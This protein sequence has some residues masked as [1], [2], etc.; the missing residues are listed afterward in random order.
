M[1]ASGAVRGPSSFS[2]ETPRDGV[3]A[4][5]ALGPW[6]AVAVR[7][8]PSREEKRA[9]SQ[10]FVLAG[11]LRG[12]EQEVPMLTIHAPAR[13]LVR[14][15][16][17]LPILTL[18]LAVGCGAPL[19]EAEESP[20]AVD[21]SPIVRGAPSRGKDPA[22]VALL[23]GESGL[24]SGTLVAPDLVLTARHCVSTTAAGIDCPSRTRH[25]QADRDPKTIAVLAGDSLAS[26]TVLARGAASV[27]LPSTS[28]CG[29]DIAFLVL[30]RALA[31]PKPAALANVTPA[32]GVRVRAVG[33]GRGEGSV[34][35]GEKRAREHVRITSVTPSEFQVG[36]ATCSGDSGG[37]AFEMT[38]GGIVGVVSRGRIPCDDAS[39]ANT[40]TRVDAHGDLFARALAH[41]LRKSKVGIGAGGSPSGAATDV[42]G[43]CAV[44]AECTTAIC[45]RDAR[46]PYCTRS[47]GSGDRCPRGFRCRATTAEGLRACQR[48]P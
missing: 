18:T 12:G 5:T 40:Y 45:L 15:L 24:C 38:S 6:T 3:G 44:A 42:G 16:A 36:E 2:S 14:V 27:V 13:P 43:T 26:G 8:R 25:V 41:P 46:G 21:A 19:E 22:V 47:C 37:P 31:S 1:E 30:D 11:L 20:I 23:I 48:N 4:C 17:A 33:F 32:A 7:G 34:R 35:A 10:D 28:L 9:K 39:A 29:N